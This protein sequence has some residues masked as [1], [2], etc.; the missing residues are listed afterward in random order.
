MKHLRKYNE[1][2][3]NKDNIKEYM[4]ACFIE[5]I[6]KGIAIGY[7]QEFEG[8]E[9]EKGEY[10]YEIDIRV[11]DCWMDNGYTLDENIKSS[12]TIVEFY[13]DI[14]NSLDKVKLKYPDIDIIYSASQDGHS[15]EVQILLIERLW[16]F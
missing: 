8:D 4:D 3:E 1:G 5:F 15:K 7:G 9:Y 10:K 2:I 13:L 16:T 12:Q 6:D 14:E 11:P